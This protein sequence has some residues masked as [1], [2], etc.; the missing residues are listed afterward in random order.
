MRPATLLQRS[1]F[2][3]W[4][5]NLA[6][7]AGV[8]V[9]V[10]VLAGALTVGASVRA[11]LRALAVERL[12]Q[13][14]HAVVGSGFFR[15]ELAAAFQ[16]S[17]P[18]IAMEGFVTEQDSGRRA[19]RVQVYAVDERFWSLQGIEMD[20][21]A[22]SQAMVSE[23]LAA[24]LATQPGRSVILRVEQAS[25]IPTDSLH[26]RKENAGRSLRLD[27][28][29]ILRRDQLGEFSLSPR[30]GAVRAIFVPL[31]R[32]RQLLEQ[33]R[34]A[35]AII[36]AGAGT[37]VVATER[38]LREAAAVEDFGLTI[39][40]LESRQVIALE[41]RSTMLSEALAEASIRVADSLG[42]IVVPTL[43]YLAN[44]IRA[45]DRTIPYSVVTALDLAV[46][47]LAGPEV[48]SLEPGPIFL[49]EWA[50]KDLGASPGDRVSIDYYVWEP[51][52]RLSTRQADFTVARVLGM[53]G[54]AADRDLVPEYPGI[55]DSDRLA[56]WDPPFP[57][58]LQRIRPVDEEYL[59]QS[60]ARRRRPLSQLSVASRFGVRDMEA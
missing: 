31:E 48:R 47:G 2:H 21:L 36:I 50:A 60:T 54:I 24:E 42:L 51:E 49:N 37:D 26:G 9:A 10:A 13:V 57:V 15:D 45:G 28:R 20:E 19:S 58:D 16:R 18:L 41:S 7:I 22:P 29:Q 32:M 5:V 23:G 56:D 38:R 44:S 53:S 25:A 39:R 4:R 52:G 43:T 14:D 11:S 34:R 27:V 30:Q 55:T 46:L 35:N 3:Y 59:G 17:A 33:P 6:V 1:L 40:V 8:A 12:G